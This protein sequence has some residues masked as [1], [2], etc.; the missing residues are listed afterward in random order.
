MCGRQEVF[1]EMMGF[2]WEVGL[3]LCAGGCVAGRGFQVRLRGSYWEISV[4][5]KGF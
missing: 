2:T 3:R 4:V 5:I 1:S